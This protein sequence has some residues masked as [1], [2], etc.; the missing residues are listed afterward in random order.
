LFVFLRDFTVASWRFND[1]QVTFPKILVKPVRLNPRAGRGY[2]T[3]L[4]SSFLFPLVFPCLSLLQTNDNVSHKCAPLA[5]T[6]LKNYSQVAHNSQDRGGTA[7]KI[8]VCAC[9]Q[10][11]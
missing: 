2:D 10:T 8:F 5:R 7:A 4:P 6:F 3:A 11:D 1:G 9:G